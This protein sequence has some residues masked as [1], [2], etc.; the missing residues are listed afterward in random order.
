[1]KKD[2]TI[3]EAMFLLV[4]LL[5]MIGTCIIS[6]KLPAHVAILF[7]LALVILFAAVK[8]VSWKTIHEGIQEGI[9]PGLVPIIIFILIGALISAWIAAGTIP[10]IMVYGFSVLSVKF[11]LPTVFIICGVVGATVGSSFTT[12]F[13]SGDC[14]FWNGTNHGI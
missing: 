14:L 3:K 4:V 12:Y 1:M 11:F 5:A 9:T 6:F 7:A 13:N 8:E 2:V 10:T